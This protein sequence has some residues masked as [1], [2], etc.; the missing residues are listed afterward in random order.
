MLTTIGEGC[1]AM[2]MRRGS[3]L[4]PDRDRTC[5]RGGRRRARAPG[6]PSSYHYLLDLDVDLAEALDVRMRLAA[7]PAVDRVHVRRRGRRGRSW[8]NG[9]RRRRR[10]RGA[11][12][13]R[14]CWRS[15]C[16]SATAIASELLGPGDLIEPG[17]LGEDE[18]LACAIGWRALVP[19]RFAVLDTGFADRVAAV[20]PDHAGPAAPR[21]AARAPSQRAARDRLPAAA[22][23]APG[24][25][26]VA[27]RGALGSGRAWRHP[28]SRCR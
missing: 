24:P 7:R 12:A 26:A 6:A 2:T 4:R 17:E 9:S 20:A 10:A 21:R 5:T 27:P 13:R 23:G 8:P 1:V 15:T 18:L 22:R 16:A 19:I 11:D 28:R 14:A 25:A 3:T